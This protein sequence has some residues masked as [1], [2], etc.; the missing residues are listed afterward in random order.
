MFKYKVAYGPA[1]FGAMYKFADGSGGCNYT[2][3]PPLDLQRHRDAQKCYTPHNDA[4]QINLGGT[5]GGFDVDG[6]SAS[7]S[8]R[9][10]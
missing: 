7:I 2:G 4:C 1:R 9:R 3:T 8:I 10:W 5:Y 6:S